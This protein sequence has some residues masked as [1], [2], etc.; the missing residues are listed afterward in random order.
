MVAP[1]T[2]GFIGLGVMGNGMC[3]NLARKSGKRVVAH[4]AV[5]DALDAVREA[6]AEG[7]RS[8]A[9]VAAEADIIFLSLP[10]KEQVQEVCVGEGGLLETGRS[11]QTVV[12]FSTIPVR[13]ARELGERFFGRGID[14]ADSPV[15]RG[16]EAAQKG[17]LSVMIGATSKVYERVLP[18]LQC[19]ATDISYCGAVGTGQVLKLTNN[20]LVFTHVVALAEAMTA[21]QRAGVEPDRL[22][23]ILSKGSGDS[24]VLRNH[25][26]KAMLTRQFPSP[27]FSSDYVLKDLDYI[28]EMGADNDVVLGCAELIRGYYRSAVDRGFGDEYFPAVMKVIE[29]GGAETES[30]DV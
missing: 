30:D 25:G 17:T 23:N 14:F 20:M 4:D 6:G 16:R 18:F 3:R 21:G 19:V 1:S 28:L 11:G 13:Q 10:G 15:A 26:M 7:V 2:I 24:F 5:P 8:V 29:Q 22:L 27:A 12:D 9:E